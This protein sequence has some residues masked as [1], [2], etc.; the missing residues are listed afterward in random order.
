MHG[1]I[2]SFISYSQAMYRHSEVT[3]VNHGY[4]IIDIDPYG[5]ASPF[6]DPAIQAVTN[7]GIA[8]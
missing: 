8:F 5:T 1:I 4:D 3:G 7:G 2:K 6:I